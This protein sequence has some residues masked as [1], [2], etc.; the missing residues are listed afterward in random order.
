MEFVFQTN[1]DLQAMTVLARGLRK[2]LRKK[3]SKRSHILGSIVIIAGITL[4]LARKS[5]DFKALLTCVAVL[6]IF[7]TLIFEDNL[8]GWI[9]KKRGI[10]GLNSSS[11]VFYPDRYVSVTELGES[12]FFYEN[13]IALAEHKDYF[14]LLFGPSHGQIYAKA[15]MT[16]GTENAFRSFL[17]E[18]TRLFIHLI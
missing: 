5:F 2:T 10:P 13:I 12:T 6:M 8:N 15:G 18:K 7:F 14:L 17:E 16:G 4:I 1:Y 11:T 3:H 9:A